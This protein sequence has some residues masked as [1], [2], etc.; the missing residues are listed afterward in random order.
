MEERGRT[1]YH[2]ANAVLSSGVWRLSLAANTACF[3]INVT[4]ALRHR[5]LSMN[6]RLT[7]NGL[8]IQMNV[9]DRPW[10]SFQWHLAAADTSTCVNARTQVKHLFKTNCEFS[11]Y[12]YKCVMLKRQ[13]HD[14][15][16]RGEN[17]IES[18]TENGMRGTVV[19]KYN[20]SPT[21]VQEMTAFA[22]TAYAAQSSSFVY[23]NFQNHS[24]SFI[25]VF[26]CVGPCHRLQDWP[27]KKQ[28]CVNVCV[29]AINW[30]TTA[31]GVNC[32]I[33]M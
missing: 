17:Q 10:F 6:L 3:D 4:Q 25:E 19:P 28:L 2:D 29:I 27:F 16:D 15:R 26:V 13:L 14:K 12:Y 8:I 23:I 5:R 1:F 32:L 33:A 7:L 22:K 9:S 18:C 31:L 11:L 20:C 30:F 24:W 21:R